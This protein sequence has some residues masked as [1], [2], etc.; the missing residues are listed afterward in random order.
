M[1]DRLSFRS[2]RREPSSLPLFDGGDEFANGLDARLPAASFVATAGLTCQCVCVLFLLLHQPLAVKVAAAL[3]AAVVDV[4]VVAVVIVTS[5]ATATTIA[6]A[7]TFSTGYN[8]LS[9]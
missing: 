3:V 7:I 2:P 8:C 1:S 4:F 5:L 9:S 6:I